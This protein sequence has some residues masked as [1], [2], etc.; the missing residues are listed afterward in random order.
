LAEYGNRREIQKRKLRENVI[1][2]NARVEVVE[3]RPAPVILILLLITLALIGV[4]L[5]YRDRTYTAKRT[6]VVWEKDLGESS[7][8]AVFRGY[9]AFCGGTIMYTKDGAEYTDR[10]G[11]SVWQK[12]YQMNDPCI[13]VRGSYAA[14]YDRGG[15]AACIFSDEQNT[16]NIATVMPV[17]KIA[18]SGI[19]VTYAVENDDNA[20]FLMVY[21]KDGSA[22]DL[23]VKSVMDGDGYPFDIAVSPDGSQLLTSYIA[24]TDGAVRESVV[25]R[26]FGEIGQNA[27][28]RRVVGGFIDEFDGHLVTKVGFSD[29]VFSHAFYDGGIVF[30]S[31]KVL[32]SPEI[33]RKVEIEEE[34]LSVADCSRGVAVITGKADEDGKQKLR[35]FD[36]NGNETGSAVFDLNYSGFSANEK[37]IILY[38]SDR[39]LVYSHKGRL[40]ADLSW[41]G[42]ISEVVGTEKT[43]ELI[44]AES[45]RL[46]YVKAE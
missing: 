7:S 21:R 13:S 31:T 30:F 37:N 32:N 18:V 19:G 9:S 29:D 1:D 41:D 2:R 17:S 33:I 6:S 38:S 5:I 20:D 43:R 46:V 22:V 24:I 36:N 23:T 3:R 45:S 4:F 16:G 26:N 40:L 42:H 12:S 44:V 35:I 27:D 14:V 28:A 10:T 25:F 34:I 11:K 39:I 15:T 8:A